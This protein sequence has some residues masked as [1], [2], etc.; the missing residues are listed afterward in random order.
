MTFTYIPCSNPLIRAVEKREARL[1][2]KY[3]CYIISDSIKTA[4]N[5][6]PT[7]KKNVVIKNFFDSKFEYCDL[8]KNSSNISF[9]Q[10]GSYSFNKNQLFS[11]EILKRIV[12]NYPKSILHFVGFKNPEDLNYFDKLV[13][14]IKEE[15]LDNNVIFHRHDEDTNEL[16]KKCHYLL[17]PSLRESFGIVPVEAQ[18]AGLSCFCSDTVSRENNCG[19]CQYISLEKPEE[20]ITAIEKNFEE[21]GGAHKHF[22]LSGFS[23]DAIVEKYKLIYD[24]KYTI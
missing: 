20:W 17:F 12:R 5:N 4:K 22:D 8:D 13:K 7:S 21:T 23:S 9:I 11:I 1:I 19:G 14:K 3:S 16:F 6:I 15:Q 2:N 24:N 10:I 18:S